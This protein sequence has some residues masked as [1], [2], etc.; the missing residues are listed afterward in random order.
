MQQEQLVI[1]V[2]CHLDKRRKEPDQNLLDLLR[3]DNRKRI[4]DRSY[5]LILFFLYAEGVEPVSSLK[6]R[7][8]WL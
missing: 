3:P 8:K 7:A 6:M 4:N 5:F 1:A 2:K